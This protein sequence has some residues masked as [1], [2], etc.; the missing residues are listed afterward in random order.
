MVKMWFSNTNQLLNSFFKPFSQLLKLFWRERSAVS[1]RTSRTQFLRLFRVGMGIFILLS[2]LLSSCS[3][4]LIVSQF[5]NADITIAPLIKRAVKENTNINMDLVQAKVAKIRENLFLID[6]NSEAVC[7]SFGCLYSLYEVEAQV[8]QTSSPNSKSNATVPHYKYLWSAY[9]Q[10]YTPPKSPLFT[11]L[12]DG[13]EYP[14]L[15]FHQ[16]QKKN[17]LDLTYC[18]DGQNYQLREFG[19]RSSE[20][21]INK[22]SKRE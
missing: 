17:Y 3:P 19:I 4:N 15:Q 8:N 14:C 16:I 6:Y 21:G 10:H 11:V 5:H 1:Q 9:F 22:F 2:L 13:G 12:E 18:F 20:F 7:G